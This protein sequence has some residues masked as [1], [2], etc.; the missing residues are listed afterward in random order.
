MF[1]KLTALAAAA[2]IC[3]AATADD[4]STVE[5]EFTYEIA[6]LESASGAAQVMA[7]LETQARKACEVVYLSGMARRTD[8]VCASDMLFQAVTAI[9]SPALHAE[10]AA[11]ELVI[12]TPSRRVRL[13]QN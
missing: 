13:A 6:K 2:T 7:S 9:A 12:E 10:Y 3:A 11:S 8:L 1:R 4:L 5:A